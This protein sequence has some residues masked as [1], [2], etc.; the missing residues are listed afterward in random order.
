[1]FGNRKLTRLARKCSG[2]SASTIIQQQKSWHALN[3]KM[4]TT[5][6]IDVLLRG[7][8][9]AETKMAPPNEL[10]SATTYYC[11][12]SRTGTAGPADRGLNKN[13]ILYIRESRGYLIFSQFYW[14]LICVSINSHYSAH[15]NEYSAYSPPFGPCQIWLRRR[16]VAHPYIAR[17]IIPTI[18]RHL[19]GGVVVVG[20]NKEQGVGRPDQKFTVL[21]K[22]PKG[23]PYS[24]LP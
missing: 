15:C 10:S 19:V 4:H 20:S 18:D 12:G 5:D 24:S 7:T 17:L 2:T 13:C 16:G 22:P 3:P 6:C 8:F 9:L 1:M 14:I 23:T 21:L 11:R